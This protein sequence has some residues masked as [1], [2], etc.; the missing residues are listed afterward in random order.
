MAPSAALHRQGERFG[1]GP[2]WRWLAAPGRPHARIHVLHIQ[3]IVTVFLLCLTASNHKRACKATMGVGAE[4]QRASR[5]PSNSPRGTT[6]RR[7]PGLWVTGP[8]G[9]WGNLA[10][11]FV[12]RVQHQRTAVAPLT[13]LR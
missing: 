2:Q 12:W 3:S 6:P 10:L 7:P 11:L 9:W 1:G 8:G 13:R 4:A 5:P